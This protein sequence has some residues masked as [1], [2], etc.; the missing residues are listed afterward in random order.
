MALHALRHFTHS[1]QQAADDSAP[2][3]TR[4]EAALG[5]ALQDFLFWLASYRC[6]TCPHTSPDWQA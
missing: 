6:H 4:S 5:G 3:T 2:C 1:A